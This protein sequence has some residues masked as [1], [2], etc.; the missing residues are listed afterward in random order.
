MSTETN[1]YKTISI[2]TCTF[3]GGL[4]LGTIREVRDSIAT[5]EK[6]PDD[7][8]FRDALEYWKKHLAKIEA[9][10]AELRA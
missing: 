2:E 10:I 3:V 7:A 5:A 1:S 6:Y 4:L 8:Y 9:A